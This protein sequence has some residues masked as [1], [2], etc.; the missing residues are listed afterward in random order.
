ME[1]HA[2]HH[3]L[4]NQ[5]T[6]APQRPESI[7]EELS[8]PSKSAIASLRGMLQREE[9]SL[10]SKIV[11]LVCAMVFAVPIAALLTHTESLSRALDA[12]GCLPDGSFAIPGTSSIWDKAH[13]LSINVPVS[14]GGSS[15]W[16]FTTAKA[17]DVVWDMIIG[18]GIQV[19]LGLM[20]LHTFYKVILRLMEGEELP[21]RTYAAIS[22]QPGSFVSAWRLLGAVKHP[23]VGLVDPE[24]RKHTG[25]DISY[26][27]FHAQLLLISMGLV[28]LYIVA[29]PT[30]LS[31]ATGYSSESYLILSYWPGP[32]K[33][34][35]A[36]RYLLYGMDEKI[37]KMCDSPDNQF[38]LFQ[39]LMPAWG[40]VLDAERLSHSDGVGT[41]YDYPD[42]VAFGYPTI[43]KFL[44]CQY[45]QAALC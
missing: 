25:P 35:T 11:G 17:V 21:F 42:Y 7:D 9:L 6:T 38:E 16:S 37:G 15:L 23:K 14:P 10:F 1:H 31:A 2:A 43:D 40:F 4:P 22:F 39:G 34:Q 20:A 5:E 24:T 33:N 32:P 8:P 18:R 28:T 3:L 13:F 41:F 36:D 12:T 30:L 45:I 19:C 44:D 27:S 29:L 26:R